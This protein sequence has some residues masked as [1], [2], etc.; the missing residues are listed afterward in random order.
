MNSLYLTIAKNYI[1]IFFKSNR[2]VFSF[3]EEILHSKK[4][5]A[6][7]HFNDNLQFVILHTWLLLE[8]V[9]NIWIR[10]KNIYKN[11]VLTLEEY[12]HANTYRT[13]KK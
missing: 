11:I 3:F 1:Y 4:V 10:L 6:E 12:I 8:L 2:D 9:I 7:Y 13:S 5:K